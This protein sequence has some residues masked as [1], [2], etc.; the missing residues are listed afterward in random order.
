MRAHII[1]IGNSRGLRI[2][3]PVLEQCGFGDEVELEVHEHRLIVS[4]APRPREGWGRM[5]EAMAEYGDDQL[6]DGEQANA[7]WDEEEWEW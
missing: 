6:V 3:K 2:P 7:A 1:R 4:S 5:F